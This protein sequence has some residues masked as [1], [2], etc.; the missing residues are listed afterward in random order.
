MELSNQHYLGN[1][2]ANPF[3]YNLEPVLLGVVEGQKIY[4]GDFSVIS[5]VKYCFLSDR[6]YFDETHA[7]YLDIPF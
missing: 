2:G 3:Y 6:K 7:E 4:A 1:D 5:S